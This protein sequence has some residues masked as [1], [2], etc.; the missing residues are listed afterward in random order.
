MQYDW[1][2][3]TLCLFFRERRTLTQTRTLLAEIFPDQN[4]EPVDKDLL[5]EAKDHLNQLTK[6][7]GS[8]GELET[9]AMRLYAIERGRM[10]IRVDPALLYTAAGD[11][12]VAGQSVSPFPQAVTRQMVLNFLDG[13]AAVNALCRS[14][15]MNL[16]IIDAGCGGAPF[17]PHPLLIDR[18]M[19]SV[20]NDISKEPAMSR[21][22]CIGVLRAGL[23][24]ACQA[25]QD[26]FAVIATGEMGIANST[27]ASA[28]Y[29]AYLGL[30]P[31]DM[32]GPGAG[33]GSAMIARKRQII[34][35]ALQTHSQVVKDGDPLQI[36][37]ALGGFEI[38]ILAGIML[39]CAA[40]KL[41]FLVDGY[42]CTS[43]FAAARAFYPQVADYAFLTHIS[44]EPGYKHALSKMDLPQR[45]LLDLGL[46]LGEGTGC[47]LA[48]GILRGAAAVFNEM[49]TLQ[50][51][52]V[53]ATVKDRIG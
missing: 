15:R 29:C 5:A 26:G 32:A 51:A 3:F 12:G 14:G 1:P 33:A 39:G 48:L 40:Q 31:Q 28:L 24:L 16:K 34:E 4:F 37:A 8:L 53:A 2:Q 11:H 42:I 19:G 36:L 6:P 41:P 22:T 43:A 35:Q 23:A 21:E 50:S 47:A 49:A 38:V 9:A 44:A 10:P 27:V 45:P 30:S 7:V 20:T 18:R 25:A 46:R 52:G 13:G 17:A